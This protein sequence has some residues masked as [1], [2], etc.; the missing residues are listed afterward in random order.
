[1]AI[2]NWGDDDTDEP[3]EPQKKEIGPAFWVGLAIVAIASPWLIQIPAQLREARE[4]KAREIPSICD[5]QP[6]ALVDRFEGI[7]MDEVDGSAAVVS[8]ESLSSEAAK[9][10]PPNPR[11][12]P[13]DFVVSD[14]DGGFELIAFA[15]AVPKGTDAAAPSRAAVEVLE[16]FEPNDAKEIEHQQ[17]LESGAVED[18]LAI[19]KAHCWHPILRLLVRKQSSEPVGTIRDRVFDQ[20]TQMAVDGSIAPR[21]VREI[22]QLLV[23]DLALGIWHDTSL[24]GELTFESGDEFR[25][26]IAALPTMPNGRDVADLFDVRIPRV[27][28]WNVAGKVDPRLDLIHAATQLRGSNTVWPHRPPPENSD[29][30]P[31][32][33]YDVDVGG[34]AERLGRNQKFLFDPETMELYF[35]P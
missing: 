15:V 20:R 2:R 3:T 26:G 12:M 28:L 5:E 17:L 35:A 9:V 29:I 6:F 14:D 24:I 19:C 34:V 27:R 18:D 23:V 30:V 31:I 10:R 22:P 33:Y 11:S 21:L 32:D 7:E 1:M 4:A 16:F 8:A 25:F 13:R